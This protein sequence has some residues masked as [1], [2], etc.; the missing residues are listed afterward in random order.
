MGTSE[1]GDEE[2]ARGR[3]GEPPGAWREDV[4]RSWSDELPRGTVEWARWPV[5]IHDL[6]V[7]P[8]AACV[9]AVM[10]SW[11]LADR[12]GLVVSTPE[13]VAE[14]VET[15]GRGEVD[16]PSTYGEFPDSHRAVASRVEGGREYHLASD[17]VEAA[18]RVLNGKG[19]FDHEE[20]RLVDCAPAPSVLRRDG[21]GAVLIAP[22]SD[23]L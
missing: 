13:S 19:R 1:L 4:A 14:Y 8:N 17:R 23:G 18:L 6:R 20:Y 16:L 7:V 15:F 3:L 21:I 22:T 12:I 10:S 2:V 11:I 5:T 9:P